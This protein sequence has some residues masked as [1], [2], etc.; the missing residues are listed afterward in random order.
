MRKPRFIRK[1]MAPTSRA[2]QTGGGIAYGQRAKTA[3]DRAEMCIRDSEIVFIYRAGEREEDTART[4]RVPDEMFE[5]YEYSM[6]ESNP[7]WRPS[8]HS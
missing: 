5:K 7:D 4:V 2:I 1:R 3:K 6:T 8:I